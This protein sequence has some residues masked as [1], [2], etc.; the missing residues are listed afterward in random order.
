MSGTS[1]TWMPPST[2]ASPAPTASIE[3]CQTVRLIAKITPAPR[4]SRRSRLERVAVAAVLDAGEQP[5]R[6]QRPQA[7]EHRG[8]GGGD[9]GEPHQDAAEGDHQRAEH[10][11]K[12][13]AG[14][15]RQ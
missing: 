13:G 15:H 14:I 1:T 11:G 12:D 9:V 10:P 8:G 2:V 7:A 3:W 4:A 5:Q 6:R